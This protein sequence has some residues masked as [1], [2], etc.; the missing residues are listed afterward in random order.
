[1]QTLPIISVNIWDMLYALLNLLILFL[2]VKKFLYKPVKKMLA[3]R[4]ATIDNEYKNAEDAKEKALSD[5]KLYE[6][7]LSHAEEE[8][9]S[10]IQSAVLSARS[11]ESQILAE[12]KDQA[13]GILRQAEANAQ[14]EL[15]KAEQTIREEIVSVGTVMAG[16]LL[17][18]EVNTDDHQ[19]MI[20]SF[21]NNIGE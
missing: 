16:K 18:R 6:E 9:D 5:Q 4:Q 2:L 3:N 20:D 21:L 13:N 1:M 7:K 19:K 11:R 10:L 12:A 17:E 14:L 8:A 15:K